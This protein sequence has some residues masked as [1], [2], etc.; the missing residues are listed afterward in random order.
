MRKYS[1]LW[2]FIW[3]MARRNRWLLK[4]V[5]ISP[6][7]PL[8]ARLADRWV[9]PLTVQIASSYGWERAAGPRLQRVVLET[10]FK[11]RQSFSFNE[12]MPRL[13]PAKETSFFFVM[14]ES[15]VM[16]TFLKGKVSALLGE[17]QSERQVS[18]KVGIPKT[19]VH[20][21]K[22]HVFKTL[23]LLTGAS[24]F[25][26]QGVKWKLRTLQFQPLSIFWREI[27]S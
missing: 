23:H 2:A 6:F 16:T 13:K 12:K 4:E 8:L 27:L 18:Q 26:D 1:F 24:D 5:V 9:I 25:N 22:W 14:A 10:K 7:I 21:T 3:C 19:T 20:R 11:I 15:K 17:G